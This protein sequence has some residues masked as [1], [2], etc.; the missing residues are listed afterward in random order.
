MQ[1]RQR[2]LGHSGALGKSQP[3]ITDLERPATRNTKTAYT[4]SELV[5]HPLARGDGGG[6]AAQRAVATLP[7]PQKQNADHRY[8]AMIGTRLH[9]SGSGGI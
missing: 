3:K 7:G 9:E 5:T 6:T 1:T 2:E 8:Q 4:H